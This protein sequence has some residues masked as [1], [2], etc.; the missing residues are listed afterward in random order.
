MSWN[1]TI[2]FIVAR[3]CVFGN[4]DRY[5]FAIGKVLSD[6][7]IVDGEIVLREAGIR[8]LDRVAR[9]E[10]E[11]VLAPLVGVICLQLESPTLRV[12]ALL[13][14][15]GAIVGFTCAARGSLLSIFFFV[16]FGFISRR[17]FALSG[18]TVRI[19]LCWRR[20]GRVDRRR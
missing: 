1:G 18:L 13:T 11:F 9:S 12:L 8:Y 3:F 15:N 6:A 2:K 10:R 14:I 19:Y 5:R 7:E 4:C 20:S 16:G 17:R